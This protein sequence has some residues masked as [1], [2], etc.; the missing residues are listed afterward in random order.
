MVATGLAGMVNAILD[1]QENIPW[2]IIAIVE[3]GAILI[4]KAVYDQDPEKSQDA[5]RF[6]H[7]DYLE[8]LQKG[9]RVMDST[10]ISLCME[11]QLPVVVFNIGTPRNLRRLIEGE[12]IGTTV[13]EPVD[14]KG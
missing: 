13:G 8:V 5:V 6:D 4:A 1:G 10:A 2:L 9:L 3:I 11:N 14:A 12:A 7:I